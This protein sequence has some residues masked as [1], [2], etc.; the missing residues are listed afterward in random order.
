LGKSTGGE[1]EIGD[2]DASPLPE[3][4]AA[5]EG[6]AADPAQ[7]LGVPPLRAKSESS[8]GLDL[9]VELDEPESLIR[10]L[11][12]I[13]GQFPKEDKRW[14]GILRMCERAEEYFEHINKPQ[15]NR[16]QP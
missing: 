15:A 4:A 13:A 8:P 2:T 14:L 3:G 7:R 1:D 5:L 12:K 10:E 16:P 9:L 11:K 6:S